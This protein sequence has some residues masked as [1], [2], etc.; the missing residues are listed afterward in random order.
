MYTIMGLK[1]VEK[2]KRGKKREKVKMSPGGSDF[3]NH[4][5]LSCSSHMGVI[6]LEIEGHDAS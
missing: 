5:E 2:G 4:A 6:R 3:L 1:A